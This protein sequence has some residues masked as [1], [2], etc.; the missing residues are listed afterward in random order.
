VR[1]VHGAHRRC[2][3]TQNCGKHVLTVF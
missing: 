1:V 2:I 3:E